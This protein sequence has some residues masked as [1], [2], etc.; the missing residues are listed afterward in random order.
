MTVASLAYQRILVPLDG[1][2]TAE[3]AIP[4]AADL[5][6]KHN[7]ELVL[8]HLEYLPALT[9]EQSP[10]GPTHEQAQTHLTELRNQLHAEGIRASEHVI[11][12]RD[13]SETLFKFVEAERISVIVMSVQGRVGMLRW[14]FGNQIEKALGNLSVPLMLVR[15]VYHKIV[16]P[17]D[18]SRWSETA[19]PQAVDIARAHNAE[20]VLLHIYQ[21]PVSGYTAQIALAGQQDIAEQTYE[22]IHD[23]LIGLRNTLRSQGLRV[24]EQMIRSNNPAQAICEFVES[25]EG[26]SMVVMT[27]HGR[28]GL[29]RWLFGSVAQKVVK[30]LR[31][32]VTLVR[33]NE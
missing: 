7:A 13:L 17:L 24:R 33:P 32:P 16:V 3:F 6:R 22:Q 8:L 10:D 14:L 30:N 31:C 9:V 20:L 4:Y 2:E 15:P 25:E 23:H 11:E 21:S 12:S 27:T 28:T 29:S 18:G 5:A 1:S 26:V 19:I